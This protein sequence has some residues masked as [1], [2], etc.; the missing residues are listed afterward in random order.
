MSF[1]LGALGA[2]GGSIGG[3]VLGP[4]AATL[5]AA[6]GLVNNYINY[7]NYKLQKDN[8][9]YQKDLQNT[10][11]M[12]EDSSI[13]R[14]IADLNASG[15][16]PVLAAG[17]GAG[18]GS[19]VSTA[20]P[21]LQG[22]S[23]LANQAMALMTQE[24]NIAKTAAEKDLVEAQKTK[25][26]VETAMNN[27]D[28]AL[29]KKYGTVVRPSGVTGTLSGVS[30]FMSGAADKIVNKVESAKKAV[31]DAKIEKKIR[32]NKENWSEYNKTHMPL[33]G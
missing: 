23:D 16:S 5:G 19:V 33:R 12:R 30:G 1:G 29:A 15:L 14:R 7:K 17:Q 8:Y 9:N 21:Q 32:E 6:E 4:A 22:M 2:L 10:I 11:F 27:W 3:S 13:Q 20:A 28:F 26:N 31:D 24:A 25:V 18:T